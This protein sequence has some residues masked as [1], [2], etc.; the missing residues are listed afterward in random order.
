MRS[1]IDNP[2]FF[3]V[4]WFQNLDSP[5][6]RRAFDGENYNVGFVRITDVPYEPMVRAAKELNRELYNR[7]YGE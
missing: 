3:G 2:Y 6:S 1:M 7:K 4:H 5:T